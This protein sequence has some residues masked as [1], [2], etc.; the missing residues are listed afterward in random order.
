[1]SEASMKRLYDFFVS[2]NDERAKEI[3]AIPRYSHFAAAEVEEEKPKAKPKK[4][5]EKVKEGE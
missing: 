4:E 5:K 3:L 1:M 2:N